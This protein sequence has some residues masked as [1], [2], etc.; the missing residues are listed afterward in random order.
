VQ[1][2]AAANN[3]TSFFQSSAKDNIGLKDVFQFLADE[4]IKRF[5]Q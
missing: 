3:F 4:I 1:E 5:E 2:V